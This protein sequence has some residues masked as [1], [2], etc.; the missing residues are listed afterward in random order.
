MRQALLFRPRRTG[1]V[2]LEGEGGSAS[3]ATALLSSTD[4]AGGGDT[5]NALL[6]SSDCAGGGDTSKECA[7]V[8]SASGM[9][10]LAHPLEYCWSSLELPQP[11]ESGSGVIRSV[12]VAVSSGLQDDSLSFSALN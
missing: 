1:P 12:S 9:L 3:S 4:C 10:S 7:L 8:I 6:S 5:S 11:S 2:V